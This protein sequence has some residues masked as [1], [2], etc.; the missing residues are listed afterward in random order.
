M[1]GKSCFRIFRDVFHVERRL[2]LVVSRQ[3]YPLT[4]CRG[5]FGDV[6][7]IVKKTMSV[8]SLRLALETSRVT[9]F[10]LHIHDD[11]SD[12]AKGFTYIHHHQRWKD[13]HRTPTLTLSPRLRLISQYDT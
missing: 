13:E 3:Q 2:H 8:N 12:I 4:R 9:A 5:R 11:Y 10:R 6:D 7:D 1:E